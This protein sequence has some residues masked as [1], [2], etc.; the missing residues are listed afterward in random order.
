MRGMERV[1]GSAANSGP[2]TAAPVTE[3]L[4]AEIPVHVSAWTAE[5]YATLSSATVIDQYN[6]LPIPQDPALAETLG[7]A[8][9]RLAKTPTH[10]RSILFQAVAISNVLSRLNEVHPEAA[11]GIVWRLGSDTTPFGTPDLNLSG[12]LLAM[13]IAN[14]AARE[15]IA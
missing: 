9:E 14:L 5:A 15:N 3:D 12:K 4:V 1:Q 10:D 2:D 11:K 7:I 13:A 8:L 6:T